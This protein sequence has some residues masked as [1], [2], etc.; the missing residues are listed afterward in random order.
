MEKIRRNAVE[1]IEKLIDKIGL[2]P[3]VKKYFEEGKLYYSYITASGFIGS[4]DTTDYDERYPKIVAACEKQFNCLVY[5]AIE[6]GDMLSLLYV[7]PRYANRL[8]GNT[9]IAYV[10]NLKAP[11]RPDFGEI[12]LA[13]L[14]GALVRIDY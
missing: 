3:N 14:H 1:N 8:K 10:Y 12:R 7:K 6:S 13:S 9:I 2:N 5:H 4:I 11:E